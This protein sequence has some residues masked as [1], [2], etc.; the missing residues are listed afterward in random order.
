MRFITCPPALNPSVPRRQC[1]PRGADQRTGLLSAAAGCPRNHGNPP[2]PAVPAVPAPPAPPP[3]A[4]TNSDKTG[5]AQQVP[6]SASVG[7][8]FTEHV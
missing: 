7:V 1:S 6:S 2:G 4:R 5:N 3:A 8:F